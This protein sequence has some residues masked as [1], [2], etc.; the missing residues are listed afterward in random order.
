MSRSGFFGRLFTIPVAET[1]NLYQLPHAL[2]RIAE[3]AGLDAAMKVALEMRGRRLR[4]PRSA[5]GSRL[6]GIV[7]IDA[8]RLI[9]EDL[10]DEEFDIPL[11][12][13]PLALW[14]HDNQYT[15]PAIAHRLGISR[16]TL[17]YWFKG[18]TPSR[19]RDLFDQAV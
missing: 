18:N 13:K 14:M 3:S 15:V 6:A 10:A 2:R 1:E 11:F 16:R 5:T 4:I 17:N 19:Q 12:K 9:V 7:G 8:A